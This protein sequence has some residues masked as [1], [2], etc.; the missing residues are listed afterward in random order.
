MRLWWSFIR[1]LTGR[2]RTIN[3][4][5]QPLKTPIYHAPHK[6]VYEW[7]NRMCFDKGSRTS[8]IMAKLRVVKQKGSNVPRGRKYSSPLSHLD[9]NNHKQKLSY[10]IMLASPITHK[11][12][13][14]W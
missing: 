6:D 2:R 4:S 13:T 8:K 11:K 12:I 10:L 14:N 1:R 3:L 9:K 7:F 5:P